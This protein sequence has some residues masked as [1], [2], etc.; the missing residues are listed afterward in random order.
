MKSDFIS[1]NLFWEGSDNFKSNDPQLKKLNG[2]SYIHRSELEESIPVLSP[3]IY[4]L[5]GGRQV[6]KST[7]LKLLIRD[8]LEQNKIEAERIFYLPCDTIVEFKQLIFEINDFYN[9]IDK[10][11]YF[12]LFIDEITYVRDW[13]RAIKS[14]ADAGVFGNA[15]VVITGSDSMLLKE[16]MMMFP[17]RRGRSP[18]VDF[19][20]YP[21][22]FAE[23][24]SLKDKKLAGDL[25]DA[26]LE[27]D[28]DNNVFT[29]NNGR[30]NDYQIR[31]LFLY[32]DEYLLTG[33]YMPAIN[34]IAGGGKILTSTYNTYI[35]WIVGDMLKRG[36]Q[37]SYLREIISALIPR[38]CKQI[39]WNNL[40]NDVAIEHH[41]TIADYV[42]LLQRMDVVKIFSALREDK[43]LAAPKKA[44]K[45]CFSDPFIFHALHGYIKTEN[46]I[47]ELAK[48]SVGPKSDLKNSLVE[49]VIASLFGRKWESYYIKAEGEVDIAIVK[50]KKFLPIEVKNS[51]TLNKRDLKQIIK[52]PSG[53]VGY[54]GYESGKFEHLDVIPIPLLAVMADNL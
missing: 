34:D 37:E 36:K 26:G 27:F 20:L 5:T 16:A 46:N 1:H 50:N 4:I 33:G 6:G 15:S 41:Q 32:F 7:L 54:A 51:V 53:V 43:M 28:F 42:E 12:I 25:G 18:K 45:V 3:G 24:I 48:T 10:S 44:K 22:S 47:F 30:L 14:F 52:Y 35:Q 29:I 31:S 17:G 21:L 40:V 39:S 49:G 8:L 38:M 2:L 11:K 9:S 13:E 23:L 19:H